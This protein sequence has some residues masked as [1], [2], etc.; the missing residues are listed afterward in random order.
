MSAASA[1]TT[2]KYGITHWKIFRGKQSMVMTGYDAKGTAV[3]GVT[4][5]FCKEGEDRRI[6]D[7]H[8]D[9]RR[10]EIQRRP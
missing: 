7:R 3:K 4:V 10:L 9:R 8:P 6:A 2:A 5:G 1:E